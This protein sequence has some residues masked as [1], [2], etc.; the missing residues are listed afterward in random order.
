[1]KEKRFVAHMF[2]GDEKPVTHINVRADR[3]QERDG[4]VF[5]YDNDRLVAVV[6]MGVLNSCQISGGDFADGKDH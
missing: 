2:Y 6:D 4:F 1:M 5:V 3:M